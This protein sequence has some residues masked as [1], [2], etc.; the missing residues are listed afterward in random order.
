MKKLSLKSSL[1]LSGLL[2]VGL[3]AAYFWKE[4]KDQ[5]AIASSLKI[6]ME[7]EVS[8]HEG[9]GLKIEQELLEEKGSKVLFQSL[10]NAGG[11][12]YSYLRQQQEDYLTSFE[13]SRKPDLLVFSY[14]AK[15]T[16][17]EGIRQVSLVSKPF[18]LKNLSYEPPQTEKAELSTLYLDNQANV[19]SLESLIRD[20][21]AFKS[22]LS[23]KLI[24]AGI[25]A[26]EVPSVLDPFFDRL[27]EKNWHIGRAGIQVDL[28]GF[29]F[30]DI[31]YSDLYEMM[32]AE[33]LTGEAR[34]AYETY[35]AEKEAARLAEEERLAQEAAARARGTNPVAVGKVIALTFDDGP[36][37]QVTP[38]I[39]DQLKEAEVKATFFLLGQNIPGQEEVVKR[40]AAE[41]HQL[42]NHTWSHPNLTKINAYQVQAQVTQTQ[43][44]IFDVTG[45]RPT[46][47]RPPYGSSNATVEAAA[48][49]PIVNWTIDTL[50]WQNRN[51]QII[52]E[53][54]KA[55][56]QSGGVILMHD[57]H[58]TTA[59]ALPDVIA[60]LKEEGY[61]FVTV[62][63]MYGY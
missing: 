53:K 20:Q 32:P 18:V 5:E 27:G 35:L 60:F 22:V 15:A 52:L 48:G 38:Q 34:Q 40:M 62:N 50:D 56:A 36:H 39:L 23:N 46:V 61:Q 47:L 51:P 16:D 6:V 8:S 42:A 29:G 37:E 63:E 55:Q 24:L 7:E 14:E 54:V 12:N 26:D 41:G 30:L 58:Q 21:E 49:L 3:V 31:P 57:I 2:L 25:S 1:V 45:I 13:D 17:L 19:F 10:P 9:Q 28:A 33:L 44:L 4:K 59:D 43:Q 11:E